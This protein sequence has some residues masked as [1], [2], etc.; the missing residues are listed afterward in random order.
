MRAALGWAI[1]ILLSGVACD[2]DA[3]EPDV[4]GN[5]VAGNTVSASQVESGVQVVN[6]TGEPVGYVAWNRGWLALFAPCV[7]TTPQ[8]LR[9]PAGGSVTIALKDLGGY[10]PGAPEAIVYWW[11]VIPGESGGFRVD[12]VREI[13]VKL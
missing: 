13:V 4:S 3:T 1:G 7:D 5:N 11:R 2:R 8:C 9:L 6:G 12:K 10:A